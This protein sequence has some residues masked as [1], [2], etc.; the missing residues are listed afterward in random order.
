MTDADPPPQALLLQ[1]PRDGQGA[2]EVPP[3]NPTDAQVPPVDP[4]ARP[5]TP[6]GLPYEYPVPIDPDPGDFISFWEF[7]SV[8]FVPHCR[9]NLPLKAAHRDACNVL[10]RAVMHQLR[11]ATGA[12]AKI[13]I[14]N[15]P[16]RVGKTKM[17]EALVCWQIAYFPDS[18]IIYTCYG[19]DLASTS[20][21]Y[22]RKVLRADWYRENFGD[23]VHGEKGDHLSTVEGGNVYAEGVDGELTGKGAGLKREFGGFIVVDD[24][25]KPKE[26]LSLVVA[27]S[28]RV[29]FEN[30]LK[31]RRNST[32]FCPI[33]ICAQRLAP[34]DLPGYL[35]KEYPDQVY[36]VKYP[37]EGPDGESQFP[38]TISTEELNVYKRTRVGRFVLASKY[39]QEPVALGGNMIPVDK[40]GRW[41]PDLA[42]TIRFEKMIIAV[43]TALKIKQANDFS[44]CALWGLFQRRAY[45]IDL[46]H[47]KWES[48]ELLTNVAVFWEKWKSVPG[49]PR[50][51]LV[52]EEKAAGTPLLQNLNRQGVP[53]TGI[54]RDIDKAR[55]VGNILPYIET[56]MVFVPDDG[57]TTWIS[58][59]LV[60][61]SEFTQNETHAHDDMVDT[62][63]DAVEYLLGKAT[64]IFD[65][66][67]SSR[68]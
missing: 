33:I 67:R 68:G 13:V 32:E 4:R 61:H 21:G 39:N 36:L 22:I 29:W 27:E 51:R 17:M 5:G 42:M 63:V 53:A 25:A 46:L 34:G 16:P 28:T 37:A 65:V 44:A 18:Q 45:L 11:T 31:D 10:Q 1:A 15:V 47:G 43:D 64:S 38:E 52:I 2:P 12:P 57:S 49:W 58:K 50:P 55:R 30:T 56:G 24:P 6:G 59:W 40:F 20:L 62:T 54:E 14:I 66:L 19:G 48:P 26:A 23:H 8:W 9:L 60:E 3:P 35:L 7:F 41:D